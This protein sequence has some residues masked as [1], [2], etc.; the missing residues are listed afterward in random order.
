MPCTGLATGQ[1]DQVVAARPVSRKT[2]LN[3]ENRP[4]RGG[5]DRL[6][7][8]PRRRAATSMSSRP[9]RLTRSRVRSTTSKHG[10]LR[11][12]RFHCGWGSCGR[13]AGETSTS[14]EPYSRARRPRRRG[15]YH[16]EIGVAAGAARARGGPRSNRPSARTPD[17]PPIGGPS[18][19]GVT[20]R[21]ARTRRRSRRGRGR[22][23]SQ[24]WTGGGCQPEP[25][26]TPNTAWSRS[27][28]RQISRNPSPDAGAGS[29]LLTCAGF[30][31][32][33]V[34]DVDVDRPVGVPAQA[35]TGC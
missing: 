19:R 3:D 23:R 18:V 5:S 8:R 21:W 29:Q 12:H 32:L 16:P 26:S 35:A 14:P 11:R 28:R 30:E 13:F 17:G 9:R 7:L 25:S 20:R 22:C 33:V 2:A 34:L 27:Y 4:E 1:R 24:A 15:H 31:R 6:A 10:D